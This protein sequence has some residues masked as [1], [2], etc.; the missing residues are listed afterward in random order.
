M[1]GIGRK[2]LR[3]DRQDARAGLYKQY[4][5]LCRIDI[6]EF[7]RQRPVGEFGDHARHFHAGRAGTDD[8]ESQQ[9]LP[10]LFTGG[11]FGPFEGQKQA[12]PDRCC[13]FQRLEAGGGT[14]PFVVTE[15]GV[16]RAGGQHQ[17]I[18]AD[19]L[20]RIQLHGPRRPVHAGHLRKQGRHFLAVAVKMADRPG[21]LG[22]RQRRRRNLIQ[23]GLKQ[24]VIA[25]VD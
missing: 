17:R 21:D 14:L 22:C 24:V 23:Q 3:K 25:T 20:A 6:A 15:I 16:T 18:E 11:K 13:I 5:G 1:P 2:I 4:A 7:R 8:D 10:L 9:R 12:A 19:H